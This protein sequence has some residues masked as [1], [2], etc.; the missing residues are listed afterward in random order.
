MNHH[1]GNFY[2]G[3]MHMGWWFLIL[4]LAIVI[5]GG[6]SWSRKRKRPE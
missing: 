2:F 5:V 6:I 4:V 3:G 1:N